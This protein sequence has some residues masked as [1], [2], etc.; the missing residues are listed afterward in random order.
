MAK[1]I[2]SLDQ[3]TSSSRAIVFDHKGQIRSVAQREFTQYFPK[4]GWVEHDADEIFSTQLEVARQ[5]LANVYSASAIESGTS[6]R[7]STMP[8]AVCSVGS[9]WVVGKNGDRSSSLDGPIE[10]RASK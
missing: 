10:Y 6:E 7:L 2:L 9:I 3:G 1:Y 4:P 5:A 8:A